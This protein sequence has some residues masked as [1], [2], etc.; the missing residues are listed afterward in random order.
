MKVP[1]GLTEREAVEI[2]YSAARAVAPKYRFGY[3]SNEDM[4][5]QGVLHALN[6]LKKK[7]F[8]PKSGEKIAQQLYSFMKVCI[9]NKLFNYQ[10][11]HSCRYTNKDTELNRAKYNI[12]HPIKMGDSIDWGFILGEENEVENRDFIEYLRAQLE[13]SLLSDFNRLMENKKLPEPRYNQLILHI[14]EMVG[15]CEAEE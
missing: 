11:D 4:I 2:I 15:E 14:R 5:Q 10:R 7:K 8:Q 9:N 6:L 1:K 3:H 12:M 13:D